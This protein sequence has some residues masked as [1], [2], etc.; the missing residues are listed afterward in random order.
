MLTESDA[1]HAALETAARRWPDD[2]GSPGRL[3]LHL[4]EQGR[5]SVEAQ[6]TADSALRLDVIHAHAGAL[7]GSF[8]ERYI[9]R[10]REDWP[11]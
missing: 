6:G 5:R 1:L 10:L 8:G 11:E 4:I 7:T 9:E 2:A 3:L